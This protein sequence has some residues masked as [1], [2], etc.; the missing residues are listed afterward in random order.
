[1]LD[2]GFE[3]G[4]KIFTGFATIEVLLKFV[5]EGIIELFIE[6]IG[7]LREERLAGGWA[8]FRASCDGA[9]PPNLTCRSEMF[10]ILPRQFLANKEARAMQTHAN[11]PRTKTSDVANFVVGQT[12]H[13]AQDKDDAV[14][15]RQLLDHFAKPSRLLA[16]N[17]KRLG[18][19]RRFPGEAGKFLAIRHECVQR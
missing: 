13:I 14:L 3:A 11:V 12:L 5:A 4:E 10:L 19:N 1:M 2:G 8:F 7:K 6:V 18:I 17:G 15:R 16:A 9:N